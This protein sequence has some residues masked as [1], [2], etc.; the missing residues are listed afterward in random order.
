MKHSFR[1]R[2]S[3]KHEW[4]PCESDLDRLK[5]YVEPIILDV[6]KTGKASA[7]LLL[8]FCFF[9]SLSIYMSDSILIGFRHNQELV[10][11]RNQ[12]GVNLC[13]HYNFLNPQKKE[14]IYDDDEFAKKY[15]LA[16]KKSF[17][18]FASEL[19]TKRLGGKK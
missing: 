19:V 5:K 4:A 8:K 10:L 11:R 16:L 17:V 12:W 9:E 6:K 7:T 2:Q 15:E 14:A 3:L 13:R 1:H 18:N